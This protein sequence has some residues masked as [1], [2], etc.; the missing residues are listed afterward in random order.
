MFLVKQSKIEVRSRNYELWA[1]S[2]MLMADSQVN[3]AYC[4]R[5]IA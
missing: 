2:R 5:L 4:L 1:E 3:C